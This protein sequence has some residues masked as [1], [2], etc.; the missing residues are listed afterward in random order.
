MIDRHDEARDSKKY[1]LG[2]EENITWAF[3]DQPTM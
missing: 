3:S 2:F 1:E